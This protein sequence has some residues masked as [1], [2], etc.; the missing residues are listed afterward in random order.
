MWNMTLFDKA[1]YL[2][3]PLLVKRRFQAYCIG[4][5]KTGTHSLRDMFHANYRASHE[6]DAAALL[7][8]ILGA[9]AGTVSSEEFRRFLKW[10]DRRLLMEMD[11]AD[12]NIY[13]LD[14]LLALFQEAKFILTIRDCYSWLDSQFNH[15]VSRPP[16]D[17]P[18]ADYT[19]FL[20]FHYR[21]HGEPHPP[22]EAVLKQHGLYTLDHFL[23]A[24]AWHN[25]TALARVPE[26]RL[27]V[28]RTHEIRRDAAKIA[29]FVGVPVETLDLGKSHTYQASQKLDLLQL[30]D[31]DYVQ[32]KIRTHCGAL[33]GRFFP[34]FPAP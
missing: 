27:L 3:K 15:L 7:D 14:H 17:N 5:G 34:D 18:Q 13:L 29:E 9:N 12:L 30:L 23:A 6:Q 24:Y 10:R 21:W 22:E 16:K 11:S 25:E 33:M 1:K 28:V 4:H 31:R 2:V 19:A 32:E 20:D 26:Q 8:L